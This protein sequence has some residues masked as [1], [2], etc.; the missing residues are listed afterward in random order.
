MANVWLLRQTVGMKPLALPVLL[1]LAAPALAEPLTISATVV[2]AAGDGGFASVEGFA[3]QLPHFPQR[4]RI[5]LTVRPDANGKLGV[6]LIGNDAST[7][8]DLDC[9]HGHGF[10]G[11]GYREVILPL[12]S[13]YP[14]LTMTVRLN[15]LDESDGLVMACEYSGDGPAQFRLQGEFVVSMAAI[16][17]AYSVVMSARV[18]E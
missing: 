11:G 8:T 18:V 2:Q 4:V 6:A 12:Q 10:V 3:S 13:V 5:D 1:T 16:P 15:G 7:A 17:T 14:H 9:Q